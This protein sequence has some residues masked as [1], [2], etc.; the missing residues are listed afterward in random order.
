M[1]PAELGAVL[2]PHLP[3][4]VEVAACTHEEPKGLFDITLKRGG[5]RTRFRLSDKAT[6]AELRGAV[7]QV[8]DGLRPLE[9]PRRKVGGR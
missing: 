9:A 2:A 8:A 1:S 3:E 6:D 4:G 5:S 7:L